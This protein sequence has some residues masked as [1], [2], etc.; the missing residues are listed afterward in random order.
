M[1]LA[2][3][4]LSLF[5]LLAAGSEAWRTADDA[6]TDLHAFVNG[7]TLYPAAFYQDVVVDGYSWRGWRFSA[8][9]DFFPDFGLYFAA[10]ALTGAVAPALVLCSCALFALLLG[11]CCLPHR[12]LVDRDQRR[13]FTIILLGL[14]ALFLLVNARSGFANP[15]FRLPIILTYHGGSLICGI[16]DLAIVCG[17]LRAD[18]WRKH[19]VSLFACLFVNTA[20]CVASDRLL[21][22]QF[23]GP[24]GLGL[25]M[26]ALGRFVPFGRATAIGAVLALATLAG[27]FLLRQIQP[28]WADQMP[29]LVVDLNV[30]VERAGLVLDCW[31]EQSRTGN[32]LHLLASG[33]AIA[34]L[35]YLGWAIVA[36]W[37]GG[38]L[39]SRETSLMFVA[40]H[41]LIATVACVVG[42]AVSGAA[43]PR[44]SEPTDWPSV[45]RYFLPTLFLPFFQLGLIAVASP[46][47]YRLSIAW[48]LAGVVWIAAGICFVQARSIDRRADRPVWSYYPAEVARFDEIVEEFGLR[49]GLAGFWEAKTFTLLSKR[50]ARLLPIVQNPISTVRFIPFVWLSNNE[51]CLRTPAGTPPR[52]QFML[53]KT[54][55]PNP[56]A[57]PTELRES[58]G[59]PAAIRSCGR[60][61]V[62]IYNRPEDEAFAAVGSADCH[63][64]R[65]A[66][67]CQV[68]ESIVFPGDTLPTGIVGRR[69]PRVARQGETPAGHLAAGPFLHLNE[70]GEYRITLLA[71]A[72]SPLAGRWTVD[73]VNPKNGWRHPIA[74]GPLAAGVMVPAI[75]IARL[76]NRHRGRALECLIHYSGAGSLH[77]HSLSVERLR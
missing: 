18:A 72:S 5:G 6:R 58:F 40:A 10:R 49:D 57:S 41:Y 50:G 2:I 12:A 14:G 62:F 37:R 22:L 45:S 34:C 39:G 25:G 7:D 28:P 55:R 67:R 65:E 77:V 26:M 11:A 75:A 48:S 66:W 36:R 71:S 52:Y 42:V 59:E 70:V 46:A 17:L 53:V 30:L 60:F 68:G 20:L 3:I 29:P 35:G 69:A 8:A 56:T 4:L 23:V 54:R 73:L 27:L 74:E 13:P 44:P 76:G 21:I 15:F 61:Q 16:V 33:W 64:L 63:F 51:W 43:E 1:R 9:T 47:R 31:I 24:I 32:L 38:A 19:H